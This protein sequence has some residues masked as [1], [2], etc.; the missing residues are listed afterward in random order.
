[1]RGVMEKCTYC[2]QRIERAKIGAKVAASKAD[3]VRPEES[4]MG[5]VV[6]EQL[7]AK[8]VKGDKLTVAVNKAAGYE[9]E[10]DANGRPDLR[11]ILVPDGVIVPACAQ[12]CPAD[13]ITFGNVED[14]KSRA[15]KLKQRD[16]E[17]LVL[18]SINTKPR[19]SYLPRLRNLNP[20]MAKKEAAK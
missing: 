16:S 20:E 4:P 19:T 15:F 8:G 12:V 6:M 9:F 1:M 18:G 2:M 13:A 17:Y 3:Y 11:R 14:Q 5:R 10:L 7:K